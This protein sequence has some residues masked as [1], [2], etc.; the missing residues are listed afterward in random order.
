MIE[1]LPEGSGVSER[2]D[3]VGGMTVI[4]SGDEVGRIFRGDRLMGDDSIADVFVGEERAWS[5][6]LAFLT[7]LVG[8]IFG[9]G[10]RFTGCFSVDSGGTEND[11]ALLGCEGV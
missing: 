4:V 7:G 10:V 5:V 1:R 6:G 3:V 11:T 9:T 2:W 8:G